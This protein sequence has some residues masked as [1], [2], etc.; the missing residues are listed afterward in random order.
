MYGVAVHN[1]HICAFVLIPVKN[2]QATHVY[3]IFM[4]VPRSFT[5]VIYRPWMVLS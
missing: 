5:A 2:S 4:F 1:S 3:D